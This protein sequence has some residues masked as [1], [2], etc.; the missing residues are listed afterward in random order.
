MYLRNSQA[1]VGQS[2]EKLLGTTLVI[3]SIF[4]ILPMPSVK[5]QFIPRSDNALSSL[6]GESLLRGYQKQLE[7]FYKVLTSR[8][9]DIKGLQDLRNLDKHGC[10]FIN[11]LR[12]GREERETK[13]KKRK[14]KKVDT[15]KGLTS[16]SAI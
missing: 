14:E 8:N 15:E 7:M 9:L 16:L 5:W 3:N 13:Q 1:V 6:I 11:I 10:L 4:S 12:Q 2:G